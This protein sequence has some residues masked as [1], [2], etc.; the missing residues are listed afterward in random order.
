MPVVPASISA[1]TRVPQHTPIEIRI[2]VSISGNELGKMTRRRIWR[3]LAP[4]EWAA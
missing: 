1:A 4:K 3:L 2:P